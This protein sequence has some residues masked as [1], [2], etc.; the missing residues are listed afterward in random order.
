[1]H[2]NSLYWNACRI[3]SVL[4]PA[5]GSYV[6]TLTSS[7]PKSAH[8]I[9]I[10][11]RTHKTLTQQRHCTITCRELSLCAARMVGMDRKTLYLHRPQ[12][13]DP[14]ILL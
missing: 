13:R 12:S 2:F 1:M 5:F 6:L 10:T 11:S 7:G 3:I 14:K 8:W 4:F 9:I